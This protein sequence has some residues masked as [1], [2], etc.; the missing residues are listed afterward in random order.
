[1]K[2]IH[3]LRIEALA[4]IRNTIPVMRAVRMSISRMSLN[5]SAR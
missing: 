4:M 1:M 2:V 3:Q 5:V